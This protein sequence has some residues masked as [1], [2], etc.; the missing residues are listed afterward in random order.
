MRHTAVNLP[1]Q[2]AGRQ[3]TE[4]LWMLIPGITA[5]A[6]PVNRPT[7]QP[8]RRPGLQASKRQTEAGECES[9]PDGGCL[10]DPAGRCLLATDMDHPAQEGAGGQY[11]GGA[12]DPLTTGTNNSLEPAILPDLHVLDRR[13]PNGETRG[14]IEQRPYRSAIEQTVRL[15][16]RATHGWSLAPVEQLEMDPGGVRGSAHDAVQ[17]VDL[18]HQMALADPANRGIARHFPDG[19]QSVRQQQGARTHTGGGGGGF[20]PRV[21][22]ANHDHIIAIVHRDLVPQNRRL[23]P[24]LNPPLPSGAK[25]AHDRAI[26]T[27]QEG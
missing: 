17:C 12:T 6:V 14:R 20:T 3:G 27:V 23:S 4:R 19:V 24:C 21:S 22:A 16:P 1:V 7:V 25:H 13:R 10:T 18:A 5:Q 15:S 11:R 9:K 26:S 8:W 2:K